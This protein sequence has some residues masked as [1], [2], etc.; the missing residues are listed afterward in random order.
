MA[1][2]RRLYGLDW[3]IVRRMY[4]PDLS[5]YTYFPTNEINLLNVGWLDAAEPYPAAKATGQF[6]IALF[7]C[8]I[9]LVQL[10][11][12]FHVCPFCQIQQR[13]G[14]REVLGGK[15]VKAGS[16]E[17][18]VSG[19]N[20]IVY[21]APDLVTTTSASTSMTRQT[22]SKLPLKIIPFRDHPDR[23]GMPRTIKSRR[24]CFFKVGHHCVSVMGEAKAVDAV[25]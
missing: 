1:A 22:N 20:G 21:A 14:I 3:E 23:P 9:S 18:R 6:L 2:R 24:F 10:T 4:F 7:S 16:G 17:I 12:G 8:C 19:S 13:W 11:R 5:P 25:G 15:V